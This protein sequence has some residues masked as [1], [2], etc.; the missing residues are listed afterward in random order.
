[1]DAALRCE[2]GKRQLPFLAGLLESEL[3]MRVTMPHTR[4]GVKP[5]LTHTRNFIV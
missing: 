3:H 5:Y 2:L 4:N 1:V